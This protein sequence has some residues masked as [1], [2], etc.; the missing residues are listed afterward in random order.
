MDFSR[1][2]HV[3]IYPKGTQTS[4]IWGFHGRQ[5]MNALVGVADRAGVI[6]LPHELSELKGDLEAATAGVLDCPDVVYVREHLPKIMEHGAVR[7][8]TVE[9]EVEK[10]AADGNKRIEMVVFHYLVLDRYHEA[11]YGNVNKTL[12]NMLSERK[13]KDTDRAIKLGLIESPFWWTEKEVE[14]AA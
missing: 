3:R 7:H 1:E 13:R 6:E 2:P 9:R 10:E 14:G 11:Q 12:S 5:L 4:A 8:V